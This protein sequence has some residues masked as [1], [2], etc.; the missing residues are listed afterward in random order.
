MDYLNNG[1][2]FFKN[3]FDREWIRTLECI[4]TIEYS[5]AIQK[6]TLSKHPKM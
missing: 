5:T 4:S 1:G 3:E 6:N 2:T